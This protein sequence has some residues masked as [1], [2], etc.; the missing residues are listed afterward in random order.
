MK[1]LKVVSLIVSKKKGEKFELDDN[2]PMVYIL[3]I[4]FEKI[5]CLVYGFLFFGKSSYISPKAKIRCKRKIKFGKN[6]NISDRCFIDALSTDGIILGNN[7]SIQK[8][9]ELS[10]TGSIRFIGKGLILGNYVGIGANSFLGC[11]GGIVIGDNTIVGNYVSFHAESHNYEDTEIP[12]RLQGVNHK[13]I[14]IGSNC[15]IGAKVTILDGAKIGNNCIIAAGAV[16][17]E[18][19]YQDC[20]LIAGVP[21]KVKKKIYGIVLRDK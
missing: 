2:I 14:I 10:C 21:A 3:R 5:I 17:T 20:S 8:N 6:L 15:W 1:I 19:E 11:A 13:G 16:V 12:I 4:I 9:V 18:G 7:V